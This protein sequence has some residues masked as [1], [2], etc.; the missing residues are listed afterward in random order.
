MATNQYLNIYKSN[1]DQTLVDSLIQE[2]I[3]CTGFDVYYLPR[4]YVKEDKLYGEDN[5]S[6]FNKYFEIEM[7]LTNVVGWEGRNDYLSK[8]G[9]QIEEQGKL[10]VSRN[11]FQK[12]VRQQRPLEGDLIY[13][14][15]TYS[16]YTITFVEH[17]SI[18]HQL[19]ALQVWN[20]DI[21]LFNYS[22]QRIRTGFE[23]IDRFE[24]E[25]SHVIKFNMTNPNQQYLAKENV[26]QGISLSTATAKGIVVS[27]NKETKEL[28]VKDIQGKFDSTLP[29]N[30]ET[31]GISDT[32]NNFDEKELPNS[33]IADNKNIQDQS[34]TI[35]DWSEKNPFGES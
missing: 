6:E 21:D 8:F 23:E 33:P 3:K 32:I 28:L 30:G 35:L 10:T 17:E 13:I 19:G 14:P 25:Q 5:V 29:I 24:N 26:Y 11:R 4:I 16:L 7:Y 27:Y 18:M 31:S 1:P 9:L 15:M 12:V 20:L 2:A 34:N 22:N